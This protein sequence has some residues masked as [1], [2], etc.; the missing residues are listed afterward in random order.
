MASWHRRKAHGRQ[1]SHVSGAF[2]SSIMI[3]VSIVITALF[4][5]IVQGGLIGNQ[6]FFCFGVWGLCCDSQYPLCSLFSFRCIADVG[7]QRGRTGHQRQHQHT[8][9]LHNK[10]SDWV[11][12]AG[13]IDGVGG[14]HIPFYKR[15]HCFCW[16]YCFYHFHPSAL[17]FFFLAFNHAYQPLMGGGRAR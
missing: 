13:L 17:F 12:G 1:F 8:K 9:T 4:L 3:A 7:N 6:G 10:H 11:G 5:N 15:I 16:S 14:T 2:I